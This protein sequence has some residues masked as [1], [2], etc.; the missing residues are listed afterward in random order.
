MRWEGGGDGEGRTGWGCGA[1]GE[2]GG[3]SVGEWWWPLE[4]SGRCS[5]V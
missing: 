1:G 2:D 3:G 5:G 4:T